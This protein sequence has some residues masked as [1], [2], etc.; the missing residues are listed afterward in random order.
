LE[1]ADVVV[2]GGGLAGLC[3]AV[4][5]SR[6]GFSVEV[7][8]RASALGG[9]GATLQENGFSFNRGAH[10]LYRTGEASQILAELGV[11]TPGRVVPSGGRALKG[12]KLHQLPVGAASLLT[13]GLFGLG[14][15]ASVGR[16]LDAVPKM[17]PESA[18]PYT[19]TEWLEKLKVHPDARPLLHALVRVTT[20]AAAPDTFSARTA[21][22]QLKR[23]IDGSVM[24]VDGGWQTLVE[25]L[26]AE[27]RRCGAAVT[28]GARAEALV[29]DAR[30]AYDVRLVD[31]RVIHARAVVLAVPPKD[32]TALV[33]S[34]GAHA[35]A[36]FTNSG[37]LRVAALCVALAKRPAPYER[38][39]LGIDTPHYLSVHSDVAH[40]APGGG[41]LVSTMKYLS[42]DETDPDSDRKELEALL[43]VGVPGWRKTL[44]HAQYL[45]RIIVSERAD[46]GAE[47]GENG[48]P[49]VDVPE[50]ER[51]VVAGDWVRGGSCIADAALGSARAAAASVIS[52]LSLS[53]AVA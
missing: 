50:L 31:G 12:G 32:A 16:L 52:Q 4:Y 15:K 44:V 43:D 37:P 8:E 19:V 26:A 5:V 6:A 48:R 24:Y 28:N 33:A 9:R 30:G 36:S 2:V 22:I 7:V 3:A 47:G 21:L 46:L 11:A 49:A 27:A 41:A 1:N 39:I 29:R 23:A 25:G 45:P 17:T 35:P 13:T 34:A 14:A 20:Y 40:L 42:G 53:R 51:V 10:A 18:Q 38:F